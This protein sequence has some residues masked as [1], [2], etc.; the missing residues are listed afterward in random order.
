MT[1]VRY[2]NWKY[3][4]VINPSKSER[5]TQI[6]E[7]SGMIKAMHGKARGKTA[8]IMAKTPDQSVGG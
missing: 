7:I 5:R 1:A 3:T 2:P 6:Q 4:P 8:K